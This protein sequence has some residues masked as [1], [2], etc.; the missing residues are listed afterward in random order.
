MA[1]AAKELSTIQE[2]EH[3][4]QGFIS[5]IPTTIATPSE[6]SLAEVNF[7]TVRKKRKEIENW[8]E[9]KIIRPARKLLDGHRIEMKLKLAPIVETE[10]RLESAMSAWRTAERIR[11]AKE[12]EKLNKQY[13]KRVER[14]EA[15]GRDLDTVA[16]P[17][18]VETLKKSNDTAEGKAVYVTRT[19]AVITDES[20]I[21]LDVPEYWIVTRTPVKK[22]IQAALE[23]GKQVPGCHLETKEVLQVRG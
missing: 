9:E 16:P 11:L 1:P 15:K 18:V 22:A 10:K 13:E 2:V 23:A 19:E 14:A 4:V 6:F 8:F 3:D 12:Q 17:T 7:V 20:L 21:P 5:N